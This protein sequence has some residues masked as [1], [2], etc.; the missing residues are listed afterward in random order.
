MKDEALELAIEKQR[1]PSHPMY[2]ARK[3]D[4]WTEKTG[5]LSGWGLTWMLRL[6]IGI[7]MLIV[8]P[9]YGLVANRGRVTHE[10]QTH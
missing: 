7:I 6:P 2:L 10:S 8:S 3:F 9:F 1:N 4:D 5:V